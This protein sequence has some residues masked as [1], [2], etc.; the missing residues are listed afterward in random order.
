[1]TTV[2][3]DHHWFHR[4]HR[5]TSP[6]PERPAPLR[7]V[8]SIDGGGIRGI[9]PAVVLAEIEHRT[10]RHA[11]ELFDLIAGTSTG[12]IIA[13]G[14]GMAGP[15]GKPA[16]RAED[17]INLYEEFGPKIFARS[18]RNTLRSMGSL[19]HE[20]YP[21]AGLEEVL[22]GRFG[23][24]LLSDSLTDV[25][26]TSYEIS[27]RETYIFCSRPAREDPAHDYPIKVVA[28]AT[29]AAPTFFE[30][31][32]VRD[33][34]GRENVFID[35]GVFANS[36]AM[37]AFAEMESRHE[38]ADLL[39]VS[40]GAGSLTRS[41]DFETVRD[42]GAAQWARPILNI[43]LDGV[44]EGVDLQLR[45]L[46]GPQRYYRFQV[47]LRHGNDEMDDVHPDNLRALRESANAMVRDSSAQIDRVCELLLQ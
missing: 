37:C 29:S 40:I 3:G 9:I 4:R 8:L 6:D 11:C 31:A 1:M 23:D 15:D 46:L 24:A 5:S 20:K 39:M 30:P 25:L 2:G 12:G 41:F 16:F 34:S 42:W 21:V 32:L 26:A 45:E 17:G 47:P 19:L 28:R 22:E 43:V 38:E 13:V 14:L 10:G 7:K 36:P 27:R 35:G 18:T 44:S 33:S